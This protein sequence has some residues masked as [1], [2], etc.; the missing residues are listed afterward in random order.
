MRNPERL[1]NKL[2]QQVHDLRKQGRF[3]EATEMA[4]RTLSAAKKAFGSEDLHVASTLETLGELYGYLGKVVKAESLYKWALAIKEKVLGPFHPDL[5]TPLSHLANLYAFRYPDRSR[6]K[7]AEKTYRRVLAIKE[8]AFRYGH[9]EVAQT[10]DDLAQVYLYVGRSKDDLVKAEVLLQRAMR[11]WEASYG[12]GYLY[13]AHFLHHLG[14]IQSAQ[15]RYVEAEAS[16]RWALRILERYHGPDSLSLVGFL[17]N[18]LASF[19]CRH[20]KYAEAEAVYRRALTIYEKWEG[21]D[22]NGVAVV[23]DHLATLVY[24][25][26]KRYD[27]AELLLKRAA[28][29]EEKNPGPL[30]TMVALWHL[31]ELYGLQDRDAQAERA[32][33]DALEAQ[34]VRFGVNHLATASVLVVLA[35]WWRR[36][37]QYAKAE[38]FY[39]RAFRILKS[40]RGNGFMGFR[41]KVFPLK[42]YAECLRKLGRH[43]EAKALE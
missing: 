28:A 26:Q 22:S 17:D 12:S 19:Y 6:V 33:E 3:S 36:K 39:R 42:S 31:A 38:P 13:V 4:E 10:L 5:G 20:A 27:E 11:I 2:D 14:Q 29:L 24:M 43:K 37:G 23:L 1:W 18:E 35:D 32:L 34:K 30:Y 15:G 7:E 40:G 8:K 25:P 21:P 41:L 9:P 16:Y